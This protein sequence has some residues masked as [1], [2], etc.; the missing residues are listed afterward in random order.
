MDAS[1]NFAGLP[2]LKRDIAHMVSAFSEAVDTP[3]GCAKAFNHLPPTHSQA[4][5]IHGNGALFNGCRADGAQK[6]EPVEEMHRC[7]CR[8]S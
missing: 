1:G 6:E 3:Q 7:L 2:V 4:S 8:D 5:W